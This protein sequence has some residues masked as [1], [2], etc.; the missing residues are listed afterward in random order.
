MLQIERYSEKYREMFTAMFVTYSVDDLKMQ[1]EDPRLTPELLEERIVPFF[2]KNM[3]KG[4]AHIDLALENGV[5]IGFVIWQ[6]DNP[7][8]DW[9]K[10]PGWGFIREFYIDKSCRGQGFGR[11]LAESTEYQL[12]AHGAKKLYLTTDGA[13]AFWKACGFTATGERG[14]NDLNIMIK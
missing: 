12:R 1:E 14:D 2:L 8:N 3:E 9:C 10:R 13:E 7:E 11:L 4:H 6:I 5:P